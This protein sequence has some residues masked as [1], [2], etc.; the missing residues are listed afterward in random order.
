M[1]LKTAIQKWYNSRQSAA[2]QYRIPLPVTEIRLLG[3]GDSFPICPRCDNTFDREYMQFCDRCG[4][5]LGWDQFA[6]AKV[7]HVPRK[8]R[9]LA[10]SAESHIGKRLFSNL[11]RVSFTVSA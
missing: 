3:N 1:R 9:R 4:Q 6:S 2:I 8:H 5:R 7:I 11:T 10:F